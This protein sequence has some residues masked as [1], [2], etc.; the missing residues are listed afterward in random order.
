MLPLEFEPTIPASPRPKAHAL[1]RAATGI[2]LN[3][4]SYVLFRRAYFY[5]T[6]NLHIPRSPLNNFLRH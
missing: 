2:G 1:D 4:H 6:H 5:L 3:R